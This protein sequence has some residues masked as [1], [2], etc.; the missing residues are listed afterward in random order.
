M[1]EDCLQS[2]TFIIWGKKTCPKV[3]GTEVV[4]EGITAGKQYSDTG[5]G[6][7]TL[8]LPHDPENLPQSL[9]VSVPA[10]DDYGYLYGAE[11][12]MTMQRVRISEDVPCAV[13]RVKMASSSIMIPGKR[14]CPPFWQKQYSSDRHIYQSTEYLCLD[15]DPDSIEGSR[16][17]DNGRLFYPV[18]T[19]CGSLPCP[20][21]ENG[22][23][24]SCVVCSI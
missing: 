19:I 24:V 20:P 9:S 2:A 16:R 7:N 5:D 14:S 22:A 17:D 11:Y 3:N 21:Y 15:D 10:S 18:K 6:V 13:C 8:C 12:Q 23:S 4:Y 1:Y